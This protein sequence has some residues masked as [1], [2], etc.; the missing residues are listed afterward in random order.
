MATAVSSAPIGIIKACSADLAT[1]TPSG[2]AAETVRV[3]DKLSAVPVT[4]GL[5]KKTRIARVVNSPA[6]MSHSDVDVRRKSS[7]LVARWRQLVRETAR[8]LPARRQQPGL[9]AAA[10]GTAAAPAAAGGPSAKR[11]TAAPELTPTK[12]AAVGQAG[13][14]ASASAPLPH[15][16]ASALHRTAA[17]SGPA[18]GCVA[19]TEPVELR[20]R[21]APEVAASPKAAKGVEASGGRATSAATT[22]PAK[23]W[24]DSPLSEEKSRRQ[25]AIRSARSVGPAAQSAAGRAEKASMREVG[26]AREGAAKQPKVSLVD[27][28]TQS[29]PHPESGSGRQGR[30][31]KHGYFCFEHFKNGNCSRGEGCSFPHVTG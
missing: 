8:E 20:N 23:R 29:V 11:K 1:L 15:G 24:H 30:P 3:L 27:V 21:Y 31:G 2:R 4:P 7:E 5:L 9:Q 12:R 26:G 19:R 25:P 6:L 22:P 28:F 13:A 17:S 14:A 16:C 10:S 18:P